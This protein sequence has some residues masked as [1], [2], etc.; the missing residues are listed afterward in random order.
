MA[1]TYMTG[2]GARMCNTVTFPVDVRREDD[3]PTTWWLVSIHARKVGPF[4]SCDDT[5]FNKAIKHMAHVEGFA[6]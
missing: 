6:E 5:L 2:P 1:H 4:F 3:A